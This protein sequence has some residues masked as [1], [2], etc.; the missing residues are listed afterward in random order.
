MG[1]DITEY[2]AVLDGLGDKVAAPDPFADQVSEAWEMHLN[3]KN[4][5]ALSA[6]EKVLSQDANHMDAL[7]GKGMAAKSLGQK[8]GAIAAFRKL[9]ELLDTIR[10]DMPGRA[11]MLERMAKKQIEWMQAG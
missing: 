9:L 7:Y 3:N 4:E 10:E 8:D 11:T 6:F 2:S 1:Y 5:L